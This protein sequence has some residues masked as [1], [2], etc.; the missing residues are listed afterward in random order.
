[1][2]TA[3][4]LVRELITGIKKG[5][6]KIPKFQRRFV[7]TDDQALN[8]LDSIASN[9][10]VGSLL[11]WRTQSKLAAERNLGDF[12]LPLTDDMTPTDY[13]LDGQQRL[14]VIYSCLGAEESELGFQAAFDLSS[15]RFLQRGEFQPGQFPLRI[16]FNTTKLLN[17]RSGLVSHPNGTELQKRLDQLIEVL[18]SYR[19]PVVTLKDL[20]VEEVCPIF[21]RINSSGTR[22]S[23]YDLMV[24]A[25]WS[26]EFDLNDEAGRISN[27]LTPKG[28]GDI[29]GDTVLKCM[30]AVL[31]KS[32]KR[33]QVLSLRKLDRSKMD[34]LVE[35]VKEALLKSVDLLTTEFK[36]YSWDFLP[37]EAVAV[38][39]T[40]I[41]AK[42]DRLDADQIRRVRQ[43]FWR[44]AF[45]GRYRGASDTFISRDLETI[46][47]FII[48]RSAPDPAFGEPPSEDQLSKSVFRSNN[49]GSRAFV[50]LLALQSPHNLTNGAKID[51]ANAL[52]VFNKKEFHHVYPKAYLSRIGV[53]EEINTLSN[54]C[55]LA[56]SENRAI[57]DDNPNEYLPRL[58][59][60]HGQHSLDLFA[61]NLLPSP[62]EHDYA[63][64]NYAQF[65]TLRSAMISKRMKHLCNG[66]NP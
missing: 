39:L 24:A 1:L 38:V 26:N 37:Y 5:E 17:F 57:S 60:E 44:G 65:L 42:R 51:I 58:V 6:I 2:E 8:L 54:I 25:T 34:D 56:A 47:N 33:E 20:T 9:Y 22:L 45:S 61:S 40:Y 11:L 15:E 31:H 3:T 66:N 53:A 52:S 18:T 12:L 32:I 27:S 59:A 41:F 10:P 29:D 21:E 36:V 43:W 7:W 48:D 28:F 23:T 62:T 14:T 4:P 55:I 19:V 46:D 13:V 30:A 50:L 35:K 64:L 16:L 49:S 63:N